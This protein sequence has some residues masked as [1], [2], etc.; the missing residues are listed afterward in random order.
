MRAIPRNA[1]IREEIYISE[2]RR[3]CCVYIIHAIIFANEQFFI[4]ALNRIVAS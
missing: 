4:G 1:T 2:M 3:K